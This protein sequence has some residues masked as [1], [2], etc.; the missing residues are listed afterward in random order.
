MGYNL[1]WFFK[2][3]FPY[4][5]P[6]F[7]LS[8]FFFFYFLGSFLGVVFKPF[9]RIYLDNNIFNF[10]ELVLIFCSFFKRVGLRLNIKK[11]KVMASGHITALQIE[12]E[13]VEVVRHFLFLGSK[14]TGD[15]DCS[16]EIRRR[17]LLGKK[18]MTNLDSVLK[19][20]DI[21]LP[22]KIR[23]VKAMVFPVVTYGCENWTIKKTECRRIEPSNCGAGEDSWKSLGQ[24]GDQ[25]S[26][27]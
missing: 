16:H 21:T 8:L 25:T 1:D 26:Q 6:Y 20:R 7:G 24:Q 13:K 9:Y 11:T 5:V 12:G 22:T 10:Q 15:D 3:F 4:S 17:L 14:I 27:S 19:S 23:I 18:A 2:D